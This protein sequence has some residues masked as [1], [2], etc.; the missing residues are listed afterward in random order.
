[1]H[2]LWRSRFR[3]QRKTE[4]QQPSYLSVIDLGTEYVKALVVEVD[5]SQA[6]IVG[7]GTARH[8]APCVAGGR[9]A[10][11]GAVVATCEQA[12]CQA[13][14]MTEATCAGK[15]VPDQ[16]VLSVPD[17]VVRGE[18]FAIRHH[19]AQ[20]RQPITASEL[21]AALQRLQRAAL[22]RLHDEGAAADEVTV[23]DTAL[24][25]M[26]VDGHRVTDPVGF[27]GQVLDVVVFNVV[28]PDGLLAALDAVAEGLEVEPLALAFGGRPLV[29]CLPA[30]GALVLDVGGR[31]TA[32]YRVRNGEVA[33]MRHLPLGGT[34][35]T[36]R[37]SEAFDLS[38]ARAEGLK[39]AYGDGR[40][41]DDGVAAVQRVLWP[42]VAEWLAGVGG[43]MKDMAGVEPLPHLIYLCGGGSQ[44]PDVERGLRSL[45][46]ANGVAF[47]RYPEVQ[48]V[49]PEDIGQVS[50][51]AQCSLGRSGVMAQ[52]LA[53][54]VLV[55]EQ[56]GLATELLR[57]V[58]RKDHS[59]HSF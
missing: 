9:L 7:Y 3:K 4:E 43:A 46:W 44:L 37:L 26:C 38:W 55:E 16:A 41:D 50:D 17:P 11:V 13:E 57:K 45:E 28:A 24:V 10:D 51:R 59:V 34:A 15:V 47:E 58:T 25:E 54:W 8:Q 2:K 18:A 31:A 36:H 6:T 27:R 52:T 29:R 5:D 1:M 33:A 56:S 19:R 53:R 22:R 35:L 32:V 30:D 40:L 48:V 39:R 12:L 20:S 42:L 23:L 14:D 49:E 21:E